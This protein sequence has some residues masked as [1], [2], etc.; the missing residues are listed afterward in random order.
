MCGWFG[1]V[2]NASTSA[3]GIP[4]KMNLVRRDVVNRNAHKMRKNIAK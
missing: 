3:I 1:P 2:P 4:V